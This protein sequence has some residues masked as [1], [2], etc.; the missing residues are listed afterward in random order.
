MSGT[1]PA[2]TLYFPGA[3]GGLRMAKSKVTPICLTYGC[4]RP[5]ALRGLCKQCYSAASAAVRGGELTWDKLE[6]LGL[7]APRKRVEGASRTFRQSLE[8]ALSQKRR[9]AG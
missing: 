7:S 1:V 6:S 3:T 9:V 5:S 2:L 8:K 4:G